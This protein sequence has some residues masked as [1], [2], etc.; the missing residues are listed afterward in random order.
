MANLEKT[1]C[2]VCS[3]CCQE[4]GHTT[5]YRHLSGIVC[6]GRKRRR[7]DS[8]DSEDVLSVDETATMEDSPDQLDSTFNLD[9][10]EESDITHNFDLEVN[11]SSGDSTSFTFSSD[12]SES[13]YGSSSDE[14]IWDISDSEDDTNEC[15]SSPVTQTISIILF[16]FT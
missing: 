9:S 7:E 3:F 14:E 6:P 15:S 5:Y 12:E 4:F 11:S 1:N 16:S 8:V 2:K 13:N 10:S